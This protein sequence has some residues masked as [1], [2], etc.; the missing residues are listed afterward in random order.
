[1]A[2]I[3]P[4]RYSTREQADTCAEW[5]CRV[6]VR[7]ASVRTLPDWWEVDFVGSSDELNQRLIDDGYGNLPFP[8]A[9]FELFWHAP[10]TEVYPE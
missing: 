8:E 6:G 5:A 10:S 1:M 9:M 4:A 7:F 2:M 3:Q